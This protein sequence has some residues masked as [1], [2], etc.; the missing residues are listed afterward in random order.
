VLLLKPNEI[1]RSRRSKDQ[2]GGKGRRGPVVGFGGGD[3][4]QEKNAEKIY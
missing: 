3:S 2:E 1:E 4:D